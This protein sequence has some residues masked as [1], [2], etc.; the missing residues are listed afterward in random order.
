M[1]GGGGK[2]AEGKGTLA[3]AEGTRGGDAHPG[4]H[5][6]LG[7]SRQKQGRLGYRVPHV[8]GEKRGTPCTP[9]SWEFLEEV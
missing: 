1:E 9:K 2:G 4:V 7:D 3:A 6:R 5:K 8:Q